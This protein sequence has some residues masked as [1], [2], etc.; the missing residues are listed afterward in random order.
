MPSKSSH[1]DTLRIV[2][3]LIT[4]T[5]QIIIPILPVFGI[6]SFV[7]QQSAAQDIPIV[8]AGYAFS[9]WSV[10]FLASFIYA[11]CQALP[12]HKAHTLFRAI[13]WYTAG[14]FLANTA[15]MVVAQ[16]TNINWLTA[17]LICFIL[18]F[19]LRALFIVARFDRT[20][21]KLP[22]IAAYIPI[23]M[24]AGWV[25]AATPLNIVSVFHIQGIFINTLILTLLILSASYMVIKTRGNM[26]YILTIIWALIGIIVRQMTEINNTP[27]LLT[28]VFGLLYIATIGLYARSPRTK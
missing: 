11:L 7:G 15:W 21:E 10:I 28:A 4:A 12:K 25:S 26:I 14:A 2:A 18:G 3:N 22:Y 6:G 5:S 9:I 23:S 17:V 13:G 1:F 16:F 24:L 19:S 20:K 8:P 27:I